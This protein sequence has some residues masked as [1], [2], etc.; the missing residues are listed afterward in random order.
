MKAINYSSSICTR[1]RK[2]VF[3][4]LCAPGTR[5]F[6]RRCDMSYRTRLLMVNNF[7]QTLDEYMQA[8]IES[9][10]G[11]NYE[12]DDRKVLKYFGLEAQFREY[13]EEYA[14]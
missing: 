11:N 8:Q 4:G 10:V 2:S 3:S 6:E 5:V 13:V 14:A 1:T 7:I 12:M 9:F